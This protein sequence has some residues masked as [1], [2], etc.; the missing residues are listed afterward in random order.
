MAAF[1]GLPN[2]LAANLDCTG[3]AVMAATRVGA[4]TGDL[5]QYGWFGFIASGKA[6]AAADL[7]GLA[8]I[9][10]GQKTIFTTETQRH[11]ETWAQKAKAKLTT[12]YQ[13]RN[14]GKTK[15][16]RGLRGGRGLDR[17]KSRA[18]VFVTT[19]RVSLLGENIHAIQSR[20]CVGP[21]NEVGRPPAMT[22]AA[23]E[24]ASGAA[25]AQVSIPGIRVRTG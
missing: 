14:W 3:M 22:L 16:H 6:K 11:G 17:I 18:G 9:R 8:R 15:G 13:D 1:M 23:S 21:P 20:D 2:S 4:I 12:D 10:P 19:P 5:I 24:L 7:R 25:T